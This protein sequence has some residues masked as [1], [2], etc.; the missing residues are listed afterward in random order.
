MKHFEDLVSNNYTILS[1][2]GHLEASVDCIKTNMAVESCIKTSSLLNHEL[3]GSLLYASSMFEVNMVSNT[4]KHI[5]YVHNMSSLWISPVIDVLRENVQSDSSNEDAVFYHKFYSKDL[6]LIEYLQ[7]CNKS[8]FLVEQIR[9]FEIQNILMAM[10]WTK[11]SIG[12]EI[13]A[14]H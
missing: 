6:N 5:L 10:G 9:L 12:K 4:P 11:I 2:P 7:H 13:L 14:E 3:I 8:A 1:E